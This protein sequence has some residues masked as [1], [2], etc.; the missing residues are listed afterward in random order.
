MSL[1]LQQLLCAP[2]MQRRCKDPAT[3]NQPCITDAG[4]QTISQL[5]FEVEQENKRRDTVAHFVCN[6]I[7]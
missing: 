7:L 6:K 1:K 4:F 2:E 3:L 5:V